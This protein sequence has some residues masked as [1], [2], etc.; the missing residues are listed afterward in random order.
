MLGWSHFEQCQKKI[1]AISGILRE[2]WILLN[3]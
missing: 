3:H 1:T 2:A